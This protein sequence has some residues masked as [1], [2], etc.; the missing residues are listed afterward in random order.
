VIVSV[1]VA[2]VIW[3]QRK[4]AATQVI[5]SL[6]H[7]NLFLKPQFSQLEMEEEDAALVQDAFEVDNSSKD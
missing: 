1:V 4:R 7:C 3:Y 5:V 6:Q 2:F